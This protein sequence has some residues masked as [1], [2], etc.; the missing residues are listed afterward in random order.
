M[1]VTGEG[2]HNNI[3]RNNSAQI[4][5]LLESYAKRRL[6]MNDS[7]RLIPGH[8]G[9]FDRLDS[10]LGATFGYSLMIALGFGI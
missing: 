5:D 1:V 3:I 2:Q 7:G 8:G 10:I 6:A 4:G 9:I